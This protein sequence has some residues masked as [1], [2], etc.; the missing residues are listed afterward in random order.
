MIE[1]TNTH[2]KKLEIS[3]LK[4]LTSLDDRTT[5]N[6]FSSYSSKCPDFRTII[7]MM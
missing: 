3:Y 2:K 6:V 4:I 1:I 7:F 5:E